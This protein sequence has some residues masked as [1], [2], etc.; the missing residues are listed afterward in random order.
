MSKKPTF[1][2]LLTLSLALPGCALTG[3]AV[4][5][6]VNCPE[7]PQPPPALM[8]PPSYESKVRLILFDS[9]HSAMQKSEHGR[10]TPEQ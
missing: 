8:S 2:L 7:P 3:K 1:A 9:G 5:P 4:S 10:D 6:P